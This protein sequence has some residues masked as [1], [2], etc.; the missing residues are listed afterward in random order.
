MEIYFK[1]HGGVN[2]SKKQ[3]NITTLIESP[4]VKSEVKLK[5]VC[6]LQTCCEHHD[7]P[8]W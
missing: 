8:F 5:F 6:S 4:K 2:L 3:R 1:P 7:I